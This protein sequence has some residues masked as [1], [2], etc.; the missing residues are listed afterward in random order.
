M[1]LPRRNLSKPESIE[2]KTLD[3][4]EKFRIYNIHHQ[5]L[6]KDTSIITEPTSFDIGTRQYEYAKMRLE[7]ITLH[8]NEAFFPL[9]FSCYLNDQTVLENGLPNKRYE[10]VA[11]W[12]IYGNEPNTVTVRLFSEDEKWVSFVEAIIECEGRAYS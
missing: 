1:L 8:C 2:I 3:G 5:V 6:S 7:H 4:V 10:L 12:D 11:P 9:R